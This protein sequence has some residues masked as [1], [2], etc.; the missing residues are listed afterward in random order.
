MSLPVRKPSS[1]P[2]S[3]ERV[4][5]DAVAASADSSGSVMPDELSP[6]HLRRR[7]LEFAAVGVAIGIVVLTGLGL[8]RLR[9]ARLTGL[10]DRRHRVGGAL[11]TL[12]H[13]DSARC[14]VR[15]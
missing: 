1:E 3:L 2:A 15:A 12:L 9:S 8:D 11:G 14:S 7:L 13:G 5:R 6:R 4:G 10:A